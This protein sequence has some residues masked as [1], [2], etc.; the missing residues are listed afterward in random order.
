[1]LISFA[2]KLLLLTLLISIRLG[3][4]CL[5]TPL[6][7][8]SYIPRIVRI[9]V[10]LSFALMLAFNLPFDQ[11]N[12]QS[13]SLVKAILYEIIIGSLF[14]LAIF[15]TF[16]CFSF[17]GNLIETQMGLNAMGTLNPNASEQSRL[18]ESFWLLVAT[19]LFV[20]SGGFRRF[21]GA[22]AQST[23]FDANI[24][25]LNSQASISYLSIAFGKVFIFGLMLASSVMFGIFLLDITLGIIARI[26]PQMNIYFV[27]LPLKITLGLWLMTLAIDASSHFTNQ[28]LGEFLARFLGIS[29]G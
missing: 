21:F 10:V 18:L 8:L 28:L 13:L 9:L 4:V 5:L 25:Y 19:M 26:M 11:L 14:A 12:L 15:L 17:A 23:L 22:I 24:T 7:I 27:S 6:P 16:A 1:V 29:Y 3:I 20:V 2:P